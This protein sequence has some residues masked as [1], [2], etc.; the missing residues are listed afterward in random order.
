MRRDSSLE[1]FGWVEPRGEKHGALVE[2]VG[3]QW[4]LR[5][6]TETKAVP[7]GVVKTRLEE[8]L[9]KVEQE[10]GR[11]PKGKHAKELKEEIVHE[12]LPRRLPEAL[13]DQRLGRPRGPPRAG[14]RRERE[15]GRHH[16]DD[17]VRA[18]SV[19]ACAWSSCRRS[20]RRP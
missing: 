16:H 7:G 9:D 8:R 15:E 6:C 2:N 19:A 20:C 5:L 12:L 10:T 11:R 1:S 4:I 18:A 17:A 14:R 3:G 13:D